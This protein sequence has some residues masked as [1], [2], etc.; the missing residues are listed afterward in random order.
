METRINDRNVIYHE[1]IK[2]NKQIQLL[3][4]QSGYLPDMFG[5]G[6]W[7]MPECKKFAELI[8]RECANCCL[9]DGLPDDAPMHRASI[10]YA[11]NIKRH[12][13]VE[14]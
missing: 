7:D 4:E 11:N 1:Y 9:D 5:I 3:A 2:M 6:H 10:S 13:G 12:F 14:S 8:I